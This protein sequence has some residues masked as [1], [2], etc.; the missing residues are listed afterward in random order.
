MKKRIWCTFKA[1]QISQSGK[2]VKTG[3]E[4]CLH[5]IQYERQLCFLTS[6]NTFIISIWC[7]NSIYSE[8]VIDLLHA[9]SFV[10]EDWYIFHS[11]LILF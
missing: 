11:D 10:S 3:G 2:R 8:Y 6:G 5:S 4:W 9:Q 1:G 7:V